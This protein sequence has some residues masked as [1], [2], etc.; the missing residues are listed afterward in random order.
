ME[1]FN[2][3]KQIVKDHKVEIMIAGIATLSIVAMVGV[4]IASDCIDSK[5]PAITDGDEPI[6]DMPIVG[7]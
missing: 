1:Q 5:I 3:I 6:N 7:E 2:K 4:S